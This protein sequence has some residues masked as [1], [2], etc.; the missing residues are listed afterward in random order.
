V[1][2]PGKKLLAG[3]GLTLQQ[4]DAIVGRHR[5]HNGEHLLKKGAYTD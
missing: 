3:A 2:P 4:D 5:V 1:D